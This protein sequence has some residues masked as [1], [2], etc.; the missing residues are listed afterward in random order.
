MT[1]YIEENDQI[2][3]KKEITNMEWET[4]ITSLVADCNQSCKYK[5]LIIN[6]NTQ[7]DIDCVYT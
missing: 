1:K 4:R 6:I 2:R 5:P 3:L 7:T